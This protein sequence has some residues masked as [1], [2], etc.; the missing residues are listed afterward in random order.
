MKS[1]NLLFI[2]L[3]L[4]STYS[5]KAQENTPLSLR[6]AVAKALENSDVS[7]ISDSKVI[8]AQNQLNVTKNSQYPDASVSGQYMYLTNANVSLGSTLG[9]GSDAGTAEETSVASPKYLLLGQASVSVPVFS[10]FK[11]KN[12]IHAD[13]NL[14]EAATFTAKSDKEKIAMQAIAMY[15]NLYKANKAVELLTENLKATKQ[16]VTDFSA[17]E[18][19]GILARND[20]LK[21]QLQE[22]NVSISL[23][24]AQ[25]NKNLLNYQLALF[26]KLPTDSNI[27]TI[28]DDFKLISETPSSEEITRN[29]LEALRFQEK[30]AENSIKIAKSNYYPSL[31]L[32][33]GYIALDLDNTITVKNAMNIGVGISYNFANLFKNKSTVKLAESRAQELE[34]TI[35]MASDT[36]K[37][38]IENATQEYQLSVQKYNV[39]KQ[40]EEQAAENF[41][42]VKDKYDNG[43]VDTNDLLEADVQ[44]L[45]SKINKA[46][47]KADITQKYF[48][49]CTATGTI[50]NQFRLKQ[51]K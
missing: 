41:R 23:Q 32:S 50:T 14:L 28:E 15:V 26:L 37:L 17:M 47:G 10:G 16:R 1:N 2:V 31:S 18:Q 22:S 8:T 36:A 29:D 5:I 20:L 45:Q 51:I 48:E 42:I 49:L 35:N 21:A 44:Q 12:A 3:I 38:E 4:L 25:K 43:L 40:S 33:G 46:Y 19:N 27:E 24:E 6:E 9:S 30:A 39:Y 7:K 13:K 11:L 34:H